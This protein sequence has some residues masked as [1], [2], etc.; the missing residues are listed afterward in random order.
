MAIM[1]AMGLSEMLD[2]LTEWLCWN[3]QAARKQAGSQN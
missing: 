2:S 3:A 1:S